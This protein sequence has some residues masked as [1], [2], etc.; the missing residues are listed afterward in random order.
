M[1]PFLGSLFNIFFQILSLIIKINYKKI[2][3]IMKK[4]L[5]YL[6]L[7]AACQTNANKIKKTGIIGKTLTIG[8]KIA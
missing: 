6:K 8:S 3:F 7:T 1:E 5:I 2:I 4:K